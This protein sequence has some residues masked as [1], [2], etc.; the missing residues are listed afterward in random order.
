MN[1]IMIIL[2]ATIAGFQAYDGY[3][4][5][6]WTM[7][8]M[9][10]A[11]I[12]GLILG[13]PMTGL[14]IGAS[15][16]LMSLGVAAIGGSSAPN[17]GM[18]AIIATALTITTKQD[19]SVGLAVGIAA[20][21]LGVQLDVIWKISMGFVSR[22]AQEFCNAG[23]FDAMEK[24]C[25]LGPVCLFL[26]CGFIPVFI[27][28]LFGVTVTNFIVN[29]MPAWFTG[30]LAIASGVLPVIGMGM[31]LTY[32]PAKKYFSFVLIGFALAAFAK[33][34]VLPVAL[35]GGAF[36]YEY[37]KRLVAASTTA[38]AGGMDEDE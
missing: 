9:I 16:Q 13:D 11:V 26:F 27:V 33:L 3:G 7:N 17:Y 15:V 1:I 24:I 8:Y 37:Y 4:T 23:K 20:G 38:V 30:G 34:G 35:I 18:A 5:Q 29:S 2:I 22:K 6:I 10:Y 19:A 12:V 14:V 21:T 25:L 32:M 36:A 28:L 31:L